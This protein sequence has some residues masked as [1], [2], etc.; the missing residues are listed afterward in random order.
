MKKK[1]NKKEEKILELGKKYVSEFLSGQQLSVTSVMTIVNVPNFLY[2]FIQQLSVS[3]NLSLE[4][5]VS[6]LASDG[7]Q[8][9]LIEK[10]KEGLGLQPKENQ[11]DIFSQMGFNVGDFKKNLNKLNELALKI[12]N[13]SKEIENGIQN[14][15][16]DK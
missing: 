16:I 6:Q 3:Y 8:R 10:T 13:S 11:E 9:G 1:S 2:G 14:F 15:P 12:T 5:L 4:E 7:L